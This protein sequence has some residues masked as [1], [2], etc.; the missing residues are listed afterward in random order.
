MKRWALLIAVIAVAIAVAAL[1][2]RTPTPRPAD[3]PTVAF[4]AGRAMADIVM[5]AQRPHPM[6]SPDASGVQEVLFA[7]LQALGLAP[8]L[9]PFKTP[10]GPGRNILG[11]LPGADRAAPAVLL[12]AHSDSVPRG[13]GA[14]DDGAGVAAVL[15]TVRAL[16]ASAP[17]KRD[18]MV[19]IT[20]GEEPGLYGAAAFFS[21]DPARTHVGVILNLEAR[22]DRGRAVMFE[23]HAGADRLIRTLIDADALQGASSLMP[24]L[25]R[26]LPNTTD[27]TEAIKRGY[28]GLNFA[29]FDGFDA[30][31]QASDTPQRLDEGSLQSLGDQ[32]LA[33][34]HALATARDLPGRAPDRV[35]ADVLGRTV[36]QYPASAAWSLLAVAVAAISLV[37]AR[38][39][40]E[41]R[42]SLAGVTAAVLAIAGL[43]LALVLA[44][45]ALAFLRV[46]LAQNHLAPLL[47]HSGWALAGAGLLSAGVTL[48]WL[49][50]ASCW[51]K[52]ASLTLGA[53]KVFTLAAIVLQLIAPL[54]AFI[55]AWPLLLTA[56]GA[57]LAGAAK[58]DYSSPL[59]AAAAIA[60]LFYWSGL[61]FALA[62]QATPAVLAPFMGLTVMALL[63]LAPPA[64]RWSGW[65]GLACAVA[66]IALSSAALAG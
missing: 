42:T 29:V 34:A 23:T 48:I 28:A 62:G 51:L 39:L 7:R 3:A 40:R 14:A 58:R 33:A 1:A 20:D 25:Y 32:V 15:E 45:V 64:E 55:P 36:L 2:L 37:A 38:A 30:Y 31:H 56:M 50:V 4:S 10:Q 63:P 21:G 18:V 8:S 47:R 11:V 17:L 6:G 66:G 44:L 27:L 19:L 54:D 61:I 57:V 43:L 65:A 12:M 35:Y 49:G 59:F 24:D 53:L 52:P 9:Q 13:P 46:V 22:G 5:I 16:K 60:Q 26:R 41:R